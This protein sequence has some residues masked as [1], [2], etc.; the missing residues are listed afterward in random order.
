MHFNMADIGAF[1]CY[2]AELMIII[3]IKSSFK[4]GTGSRYRPTS[5]VLFPS[6]D[7]SWPSS[8]LQNHWYIIPCYVHGYFHV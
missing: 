6:F 8:Y 5:C 7:V 1:H 2:K 3:T 4:T